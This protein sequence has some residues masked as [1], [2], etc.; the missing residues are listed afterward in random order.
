M[1]PRGRGIPPAVLEE[2]LALPYRD[3]AAFELIEQHKHELAA[4][5]IEPIQSS[6]PRTDAGPFLAELRDVCTRA[7]V[8]LIFDEVITGFRVAF[9]GAQEHYGVTPDLATYGKILGGGL[10]IGAVAGSEKWM[11]PFNYFSDGPSIFAGGTFGGNPLT[12]QAGTAMISHLRDHPEVYSELSRKSGHLANEV[13]TFLLKEDY[14]AQLL[15]GG[16]LF[17]LVFTKDP[18]ERGLGFNPATAELEHRYY[19]HLLQRGVVVPGLHIFFLSDAHSDEDVAEVID[20]FRD[21]FRALRGEG[22]I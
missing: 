13:N 4:V 3:S 8:P 5:M 14:S 6:N 17:H 16:S 12:M 10:P 2:V 9:G 11:A 1:K 21:S 20:A 19:A 15:H 7:G 22:R 18:V